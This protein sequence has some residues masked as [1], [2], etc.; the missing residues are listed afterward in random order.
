MDYLNSLDKLKSRSETIFYPTH[1]APITQTKAYIEQIRAHRLSRVDQ[2][3][4]ALDSGLQSLAELRQ[5]IYPDIPRA[6]HAGAE[7]SIMGSINYLAE[8]G[9]LT[10]GAIPWTYPA[11]DTGL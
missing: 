4:A 6:L 11:T 9:K 3:E 7:L 10:A 5:C 2:V 1:G 8:T